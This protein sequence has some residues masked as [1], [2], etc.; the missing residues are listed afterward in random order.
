MVAVA[1]IRLLE[2]LEDL[3]AE[4]MGHLVVLVE[5]VL[6]DKAILEDTA[7]ILVAVAAVVVLEVL[8]LTLVRVE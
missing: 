2:L 6:L 8:V 5:V 1:V 3:G 7:A 4:L